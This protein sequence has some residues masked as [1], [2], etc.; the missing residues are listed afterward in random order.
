MPTPPDPLQA[1]SKPKACIAQRQSATSLFFAAV[2][3]TH[4]ETA[5]RQHK[6]AL[7]LCCVHVVADTPA[8]GHGSM[9]ICKRPT[10]SIHRKS[11]YNQKLDR[12]AGG[13]KIVGVL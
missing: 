7:S 9:Q 1:D 5:K 3:Q 11:R 6:R 8:A 12:F 10:F 13:A 2:R 4:T